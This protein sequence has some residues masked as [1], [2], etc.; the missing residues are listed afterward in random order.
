MKKDEYDVVIIGAGVGG[1]V[2]GCYLAKAGKKILIVEKNQQLGGYCRS[3]D[4]H[5]GLK[6]DV[7]IHSLASCRPEGTVGKIIDE[8]GLKK[9]IQLNICKVPN[10]VFIEGEKISFDRE[11]R[12]V[13]EELIKHF[14]AEEKNIVGF[15]QYISAGDV[16]SFIKC[17]NTSF[18]K[19]LDR[20]FQNKI[21][22]RALSEMIFISTGVDCEQLS[23]FVGCSTFR[24]Y[25]LDGGYYP[26]GGVQEFPNALGKMINLWGGDI[27]LNRTVK[28]IVV[29][30]NAVRG[31]KLDNGSFI[32][33][34][35][36]V[37]AADMYRT[38]TEMID[39]SR[40]QVQWK[41]RLDT[42]VPSMSAYCLYLGIRNCNEIDAFQNTLKSTS[43]FIDNKKNEGELC[44]P[45]FILSSATY[46]DK[47]DKKQPIC[48]LLLTNAYFKDR[49]F[50]SENKKRFGDLLIDRLAEYIPGLPNS[51]FFRGC[52]TPITLYNWTFNHRGAAYG[53]AGIPEQIAVL[54][55]NSGIGIEGLFL[56]GHWTTRSHGIIS[57]AYAGKRTANIILKN[58]M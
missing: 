14:P 38:F 46:S 53:W 45:T 41:N 54:E 26:V 18:A 49:L 51:I 10:I 50:W 58:T 5:D 44:Q 32:S 20:Y 39:N 15:L 34:K 27:V 21:L 25:L 55:L 3:L 13:E 47:A 43:Y 8:L 37:S 35:V 42:M 16:L 40:V 23:A 48:L 22:K 2:C 56:T 36:V 11:L 4:F 7:C 9:Y 6:F 28:K 17:K 19:F 24:E 1:L 31:V 33:S 30:N 57:A 29:R 12:N 52:A